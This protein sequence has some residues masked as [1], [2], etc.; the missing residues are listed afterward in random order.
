MSISLNDTI[1]EMATD[2]VTKKI[3]ITLEHQKLDLI[4]VLWRVDGAVK[5]ITEKLIDEGRIK[6]RMAKLQTIIDD[7]RLEVA[8]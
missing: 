5:Q 4:D 1:E 6:K 7:S 3:I 2:P 8:Q